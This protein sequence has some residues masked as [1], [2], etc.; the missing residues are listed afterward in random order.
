MFKAT[1]NLSRVIIVIVLFNLLNAGNLT[2]Q[3]SLFEYKQYVSK[4]DTLRYRQLSPDYNTSRRYPLVIF[5]HG[6]GERG[7][8]DL[9]GGGAFFVVG[10][11]RGSTYDGVV[12]QAA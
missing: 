2:A 6:S 7:S 1:T 4:K 5:L 11:V 9:S 10:G 8:D 3:P 12:V